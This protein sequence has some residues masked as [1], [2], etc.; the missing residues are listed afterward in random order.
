MKATIDCVH[1]Y[2]KQAVSCMKMAGIDEDT[3][4]EIIYKLMDYIKDYDRADTPAG[5]STLAVLKTYELINNDDPYKEVKKQSND[6]AL[7]LYPRLK[8][9]IDENGDRLYK[10]LKISVAGNVIDLGIRRSFNIEEELKYSMET[11]FAKDHY[12]AFAKKL[13]QVDEVLF[14]GDNSGE[15]VFDKILVEE[16][17]RL[18]KRVTYVVKEGPV[19][20]DSTM[21]DA[22]YVGMDKVARVMTTGSRFLGVSFKHISRKFA[23]VLNNAPL[24]IAKGQANFESLEQEK[25]ARDRIFFLLKIKCDEVSKTAGVQMGDLAFFTV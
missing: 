4:H 12:Q 20:N 7:Q 23:D 11:G 21:E 8:D 15:I 6:L 3:Q 2:L 10:A 14:L 19:L 18:G 17:V 24:V 5:N 1:C 9:I 25:M 13:E 16:L 22:L